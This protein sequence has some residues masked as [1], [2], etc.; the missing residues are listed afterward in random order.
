M[1]H[2]LD[3][4]VAHGNHKRNKRGD[5]WNSPL[6]SW[7]AFLMVSSDSSDIL[8][9]TTNRKQNERGHELAGISSIDSKTQMM[10]YFLQ[11]G[12]CRRRATKEKLF[13]STLKQRPKTMDVLLMKLLSNSLEPCKWIINQ[14]WETS[15]CYIL[16]SD[17]DWET[18]LISSFP[19]AL[20]PSKVGYGQNSIAK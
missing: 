11:G 7:N 12:F 6:S 20:C 1:G 10:T 18:D 13:G 19:F 9:K 8:A 17:I 14:F 2:D 4:G 5:I 15:C 3:F 16:Q